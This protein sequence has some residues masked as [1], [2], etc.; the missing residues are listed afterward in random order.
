MTDYRASVDGR[1]T[2]SN[3]G[4]IA[5]EGFRVDLPGPDADRGE[6]GRLLVASLG[7]LMADDVALSRVDVFEEPHKGTR[8]GP[9]D[10]QVSAPPRID[11]RLVELSHPIRDG[12]VTLPGLPAPEITSFLTRE[13]SRA[14]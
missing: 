3:G 2:F 4:S 5:V 6:I 8:G 10:S 9:S 7:L 11:G 14:K 13:A 12:M 1:V